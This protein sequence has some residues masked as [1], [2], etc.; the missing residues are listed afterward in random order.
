V[1]R[2][3][4]SLAAV[5]FLVATVAGLAQ[6]SAPVPVATRGQAECSGFIAAAPASKD[7]FVADGADNDYF[8]D[9]R[10]FTIGEFVYLNSRTNATFSVGSEYRIIRPATATFS[11]GFFA[12][13]IGAIH[14]FNRVPLYTGENAAIRSLGKPY[15][16]V[17][18]VKVKQV[19]P[20]GAI[21]EVTF[22]CRP[23]YPADLAVPFQ[24]RPIPDYTPS[25]KFDRFAPPNGKQLGAI[26]AAPS[27]V[28]FLGTGDVA[29]VNLGAADGVKPGERFRVFKIFR[30]TDQTLVS[31][32]NLP[33]E[34]IG[35]VVV[36][37]TQEKSS[38]V[39]VVDNLREIS[40]GDGIE[41]E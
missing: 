15:E 19:T 24:P 14:S 25:T 17:G 12:G 32:A 26:T 10:Q 2:R 35:E 34:S 37:S 31:Y 28:V 16:D 39:I 1:S 36:L 21:A 22:S 5:I 13:G 41:L 30:G 4:F 18:I 7:V 33:R 23:I 38:V 40:V 6:E 9:T 11:E 29:Y 8:S 27:N 20:Q 3:V